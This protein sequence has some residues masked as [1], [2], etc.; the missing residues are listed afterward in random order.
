LVLASKSPN[1]KRIF[2]EQG[3]E[4][5]VD[6]SDFDERSIQ[7][8]DD[9]QLVQKIARGKAEIVAKRHPESIIIAVDTMV[10]LDGE[11]YGQAADKEQAYAMMD[12]LNGK[13]HEVVSGICIVNTQ[14]GKILEDTDTSVV[15][16]RDVD[17]GTLKKYIEAGDYK[18]KAGVYNIRDPG[19]E[20][21]VESVIG[22]Y[23]N[24]MGAPIEKIQAMLE[25]I[26]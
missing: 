1:R 15:K 24:I 12:K 9:A 3:M 17:A 6:V 5:E 20:T 18:G 8:F 22:S 10:C 13:T 23:P 2:E 14:T 26:Q 11:Q 21:F 4:F 7:N 25:Q 19:Y 16:L